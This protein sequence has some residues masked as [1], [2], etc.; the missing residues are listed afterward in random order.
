MAW[1]PIQVVAYELS[2]TPAAAT[3]TRNG[4][5]PSRRTSRASSGRTSQ[6]IA[7]TKTTDRTTTRT[8]P[9]LPPPVTIAE[10]SASR[11]HAATSST[12]ALAR[13][14]VPT[15]VGSR[16][17]SAR[18]RASTGNAVTDSAAPMNRMN[19]ASGTCRPCTV[20]CPS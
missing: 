1:M 4:E 3:A 15:R 12:A 11:H 17:V 13:A 16:P 19:A 18:I 2:S 10:T 8:R 9:P 6:S 7:A 14:S 20:A 5:E